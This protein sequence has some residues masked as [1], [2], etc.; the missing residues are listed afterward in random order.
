MD[1]TVDIFQIPI[2][3]EAAK[4]MNQMNNGTMVFEESATI[5]PVRLPGEE[6]KKYR[7]YVPWGSDNLRALEVIRMMRKDEVLTSN[8]QF[9]IFAGYGN[10]LGM[11]TGAGEKI[12]D[13]E[14]I[15]FFKYNRPVK[16]LLEQQT[17]IK[18]FFFTICILILSGDG[19]KIVELIHK[20]ACY[21]RFETCN[22]DTGAIEHVFFGDF[23]TSGNDKFEAIELLDPMNPLKD[24][25]V[26]MGKLP[27]ADGI[28]GQ[29]TDVRKFALLNEIPTPGNNYYPFPTWWSIFNSGWYDIKQMIP[30]GKKAK[31][32]NGLVLNYQAEINADYWKVLYEQEKITD[33][34]LQLARMKKEKDN[35]RE[36]L[37]GIAN[38]GKVWFSGFYVHPNTGAEIKMV[39]ITLIN[40]T[41]EGGDWI[42]DTEEAA[43][44]ECY[45]QSVH[46][47]LIGATPGKSKGSFSGSDKRELFTIKQAMEK[48]I[49][50]ILLEPYFVIK[51]YNGWDVEFEIPFVMLTTL[52]KKTDA[53]PA[54][55]D[56]NAD[57]NN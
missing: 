12:T 19:T 51:E 21:C 20:D 37:T 32:K 3:H 46:P 11:K 2:N 25:M 6:G 54:V 1:T 5:T 39:K 31:F 24:L 23:E 36:F 17:D 55:Q 30:E 40:N 8:T 52:D 14:I 35:I 29:S 50:D 34:A 56:S 53:A 4:I 33:P 43:N 49:R 7:G 38:S 44:M 27:N 42:E 57:T 13:Q 26:R 45:A 41:K 28:T 16:Y 22:P 48:P 15:D 47:S 18:Y 10:G 9:N